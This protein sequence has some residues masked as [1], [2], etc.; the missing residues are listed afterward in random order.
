MKVYG[1][2]WGTYRFRFFWY[3]F[4]YFTSKTVGHTLWGVPACVIN[5]H[6]SNEPKWRKCE[7]IMRKIAATILNPCPWRLLNPPSEPILTDYP[8]WWAS[9]GKIK[10]LQ[11]LPPLPWHL[12]IS[13]VL[14]TPNHTTLWWINLVFLVCQVFFPPLPLSFFLG[15]FSPLHSYTANPYNE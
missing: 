5:E 11:F 1:I 13:P 12:L 4:F 14:Y 6:L 7:L 15:T 2:L 9:D 10:S 8:K 3:F